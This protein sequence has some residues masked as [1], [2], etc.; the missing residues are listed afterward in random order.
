MSKMLQNQW[1]RPKF[2]GANLNSRMSKWK[3]LSFVLHLTLYK[4]VSN[5]MN[6][7]CILLMM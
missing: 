7:R 3:R 6:R 2:N 5:T 4:L 1:R